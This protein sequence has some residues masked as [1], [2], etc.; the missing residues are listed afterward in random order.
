MLVRV[1]AAK[2]LLHLATAHVMQIF[3]KAAVRISVVEGAGHR[4]SLQLELIDRSELPASEL[5]S[6]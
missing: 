3:D 1:Q 5:A 2:L 6:S 4:R